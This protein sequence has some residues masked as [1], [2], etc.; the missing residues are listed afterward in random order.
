[1]NIYTIDKDLGISARTVSRIIN[2]SP[3]VS[4]KTRKQVLDYFSHI[5]YSP[6]QTARSLIQQ[7][8]DAIGIAALAS[9]SAYMHELLLSMQML[10]SAQGKRVM[11]FLSNDAQDEREAINVLLGKGVDG[12]ICLTALQSD[13]D[14]RRVVKANRKIVFGQGPLDLQAVH[15]SQTKGIEELLTLLY[16][17]GHRRIHMLGLTKDMYPDRNE[18]HMAYRDGMLTRGLDHHIRIT[19]SQPSLPD[20]YATAREI[21]TRDDR[22]TALMC[23]ND[24]MAIGALHAAYE[25]GLNVPRDL[26]ITGFDGTQLCQF[27][28]PCLTSYQISPEQVAQATV[29]T[30]FALISDPNAQITPHQVVGRLLVGGTTGP[31][32]DDPE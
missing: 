5:G 4:E 19:P 10:I 17:L 28:N 26:S 21:L 15:T 3:L 27:L 14:I 22:P 30:I 29:A 16:H 18:R 6:N 9:R 2:N 20:A 25:I 11:L 32:R 23:F 31:A 1:M 12:M 24:E 8:T 7:R 13:E